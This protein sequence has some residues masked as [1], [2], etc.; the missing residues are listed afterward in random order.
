MVENNVEKSRV[1]IFIR[2]EIKCKR[3]VDLE[4]QNNGI[5][6]IDVD[7]KKKYRI[8]NLYR[9]FNPTDG[10]SQRQFFTDQLSLIKNALGT[11]DQRQPIMMGDFNL[12]ERMKYL[13]SYGN[14]ASL[15]TQCPSMLYLL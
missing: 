12:D 13:N 11:K 8:L 10:R 14:K 4:G 2:N 1:G 9:V 6:I 15:L 7:L 5:I 3:R